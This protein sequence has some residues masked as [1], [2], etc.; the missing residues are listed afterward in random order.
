MRKTSRVIEECWHENPDARLPALRVQKTLIKVQE[1]LEDES[2]V[3][4]YYILFH[5]ETQ[6]FSLIAD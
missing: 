1:S 3:Q 5:L 4:V 2:S 6:L